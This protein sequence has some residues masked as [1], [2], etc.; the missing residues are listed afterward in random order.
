MEGQY[1]YENKPGEGP[2]NDETHFIHTLTSATHTFNASRSGPSAIRIPGG[3]PVLSTSDR[4]RREAEWITLES[5]ER[6]VI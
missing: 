5:L 3:R 6:E 2:K 4:D 1:K